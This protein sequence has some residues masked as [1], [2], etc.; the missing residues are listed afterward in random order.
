MS[1]RS[2]VGRRWGSI[3]LWGRRIK[4]HHYLQYLLLRLRVQ[5]V[6]L[7]TS[8][9]EYSLKADDSKTI[10]VTTTVKKM[11]EASQQGVQAGLSH[12]LI[13]VRLYS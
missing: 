2:R 7:K 3:L 6:P 4:C 5:Q 10:K 11:P 1:R 9:A 12:L 8:Q 13:L